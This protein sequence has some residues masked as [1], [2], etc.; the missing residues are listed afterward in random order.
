MHLADVADLV[1][2][3][4]LEDEGEA[5]EDEVEVT[6]DEVDS[7]EEVGEEDAVVLA[8]EAF[9]AEAGVL[10]E[11]G[12]LLEVVA[13]AQEEALTLSSNHTDIQAC[14]SLKAKN[15][16]LLQGILFLVIPSMGRSVFPSTEARKARKLNIAFG[17]HS[18]ASLL[19]VSLE[20][21]EISSLFQAQKFC[22][23]AQRVERA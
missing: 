11:V 5:T 23:W 1:D 10:P 12:V 22:T 2:V 3:V 6:E 8:V 9:K 4:L 14:S 7:E 20:V 18:E 15:T 13:E 16:C 19:P 17:T 21:L